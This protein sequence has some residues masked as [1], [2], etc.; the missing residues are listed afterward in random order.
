MNNL[1]LS[2]LFSTPLL[3]L[4][5]ARLS[6]IRNADRIA[7]IDNGKVREIGS[8]DELMSKPDG[9]YRRLQE[10]QNLDVQVAEKRGDVRK[11]GK[12]FTEVRDGVAGS[13]GD[14][15][16]Q[17]LQVTDI[18][19]KRNRRRAWVLGYDDKYCTY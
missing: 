7:V 10:L 11:K 3:L 6:T 9:R 15:A 5:S 4:L 13:K 16:E 12:L 8:H 14:R 1:G 18:E 19:A 2:S 17:N